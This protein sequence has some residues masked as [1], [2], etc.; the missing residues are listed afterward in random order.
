MRAAMMVRVLLAA[1]GIN[2]ALRNGDG[3][4]ALDLALQHSRERSSSSWR[5]TKAKSSRE[6][7]SLDSSFCFSSSSPPSSQTAN[8][9]V[10]NKNKQ[11]GTSA[12][13]QHGAE[14]Q[15]D[16]I[17]GIIGTSDNN[18]DIIISTN[19]TTKQ[20]PSQPPSPQPPSCSEE[21]STTT[22]FVLRRLMG[23]VWTKCRSRNVCAG[24][25]GRGQH[26]AGWRR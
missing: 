4:T 23:D 14:V 10:E 11:K 16:D 22:S 3:L 19:N 6:E 2:P 25:E 24:G 9:K 26:H 21:P 18:A 17:I 13:E 8:L 7:R 5:K 1:D 20:P 12:E 15:N